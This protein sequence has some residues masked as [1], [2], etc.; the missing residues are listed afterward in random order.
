[1]SNI[2]ILLDAKS[3][4]AEK[5]ALIC[6][7]RNETYTYK[8]L[9]DEMNRIGLGL[10][11]LGVKK[12]DRIC[13]YLDSS[14]EYLISYFAIWRI[15]AV[16]V[17]AN[18][19]YCGD[20]LRHAINDAGASA[21]ITGSQGIDVVSAIRLKT[22]TLSHIICINTSG[23]G[24]VAWESFPPAP[25]NF[26]AV[27]CA[28]DDVCH[29]QYT[30]GTTGKPKG[31]MLTH[32]NWMSALDAEREALRL[33][34]DDVYLGIYPMGHVGLS[35]GLSILRAGGTYVMMERFDIERYVALA[36]QYKATI[37][38]GMPPVIHSLVHSPP[39]TEKRFLHARVMISGG[40]QLL[41]SVWEAFDQ[42]YRIP[43]ANSYGLSETIV[44]GSGTTTLP[45]Y[46]ELT[47]NYQ[48]VG[49]AVGYTEVAIVDVDNPEKE[50]VSGEQ[51]EIALRGPSVAK[52]YW[53]MPE[54][55]A[56]VFHQ[57]GWFL[58]GDIGYLD[59]KG[60]LYITDR[61]KDMIIMSGWKVYPTEVENVIIQHPAI[62]DVAVFGI[63]DERKGEIVVAAVVLKP[64][65]A[66][67][68]AELE[69]WCRDRLAGYKIPRTLISVSALPRVH[70]WKLLRRTL[71]EMYERPAL[72]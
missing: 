72:Q 38:A 25:V 69:S 14:P 1:M 61:K 42:R 23:N 36:E 60:I 58:T 63:P 34:P 12:G 53:N 6:P 5:V 59:E 15:G 51:G 55:T 48:S 39:G 26:R 44:I 68:Q 30:A 22:P 16:A 4:P 27:N 52:G 67:T 43:V 65:S 50:L 40:G 54:A 37:L 7:T 66:F 11:K 13:I 2:T 8:K 71:R 57:D 28:A 19:V 24:S 9:R 31:A 64:G 49:V 62:A 20:E 21:I 41:P 17:P 29:I 33:R 47:M 10:E 70:G 18:I 46:P 56:S 3:V 32:G 35:W 45:E